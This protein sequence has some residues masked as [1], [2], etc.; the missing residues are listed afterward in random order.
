[1]EDWMRLKPDSDRYE[2]DKLIDSIMRENTELGFTCQAPSVNNQVQQ[3]INS[4]YQYLVSLANEIKQNIDNIISKS[5]NLSD[6]MG[7]DIKDII[8]TFIDISNTTGSFSTGLGDMNNLQNNIAMG[9]NP[10]MTPMQQL[11]YNTITL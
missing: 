4:D 9:N 3:P 6:N 1:M 11:I 5:Q 2:T 7:V 10:S 8:D